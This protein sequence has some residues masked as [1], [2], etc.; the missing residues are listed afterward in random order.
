MS[1]GIGIQSFTQYFRSDSHFAWYRGGVHVNEALNP[2][3]GGTAHMVL[4]G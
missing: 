3:S 2:G 1:Y 4:R